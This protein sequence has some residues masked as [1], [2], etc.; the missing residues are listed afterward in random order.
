MLEI[1]PRQRNMVVRSPPGPEQV[2][3]LGMPQNTTSAIFA[4]HHDTI[5]KASVLGSTGAFATRSSN[6]GSGPRSSTRIAYL[7]PG[8]RGKGG[9][10]LRGTLK[11][12]KSTRV[13]KPSWTPSRGLV[14]TRGRIVAFVVIDNFEIWVAAEHRFELRTILGALRYP[15]FPAESQQ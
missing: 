7:H 5:K 10:G 1:L 6:R 3:V 13:S 2:N 4:K 9:P 8:G 12:A 15:K 11:R 14:I